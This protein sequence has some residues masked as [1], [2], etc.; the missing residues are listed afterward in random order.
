M[1]SKLMLLAAVALIGMAGTAQAQQRQRPSGEERRELMRQRREAMQGNREALMQRREAMRQRLANATPEQ[2][3]FL[4]S[5]RAE[6]QAIRDQVRAGTLDRA[7]AR[8][9]MREW[10]RANRPERS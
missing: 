7:G 1:K 6:R 4:E 8:A 9:A 2:R 5:L 10:I 3:A